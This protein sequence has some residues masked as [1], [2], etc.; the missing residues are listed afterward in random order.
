MSNRAKHGVEF[1]AARSALANDANVIE[2]PDTRGDHGEA[3]VNSIVR[4]GPMMLTVCW[5]MRRGVTRIISARRASREER[6][7]YAKRP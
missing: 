6:K 5:T 4:L 1:E 7:R 3:R 2:E